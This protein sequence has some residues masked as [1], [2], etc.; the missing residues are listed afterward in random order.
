[1]ECKGSLLLSQARDICPYPVPD[2]PVHVS[3]SH[4]LKIHFNITLHLHLGLPSGFI[5]QGSPPKPH[6]HPLPLPTCTTCPTHLSLLD[7][8]TQIAGAIKLYINSNYLIHLILHSLA[9]TLHSSH[10]FT[11]HD[12]TSWHIHNQKITEVWT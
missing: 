1:M 3:P 5:H 4:F 12:T 7:L 10:H 6:M 9:E 2:N 11:Q 8:F